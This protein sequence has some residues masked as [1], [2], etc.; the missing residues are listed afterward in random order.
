[1][2]QVLS[3][4]GKPASSVKL[5]P[6]DTPCKQA[7]IDPDGGTGKEGA[8]KDEDQ[9]TIDVVNADS[10]LEVMGKTLSDVRVKTG[11]GLVSRRFGL[12]RRFK[13]K[14]TF[15]AVSVKVENTGDE[16]LDSL[17]AD[18]VLDGKRYS[19]DSRL[20]YYVEPDDAF[21][22]Q[23]SDSV[24]TTVLFDVPSAVVRGADSGG[25]LEI[26]GDDEFSSP[27]YAKKL[28]RIRLGGAPSRGGAKG[29]TS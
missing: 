17:R 15:V 12:V 10:D 18:L 25:A 4:L 5:A 29:V 13:A 6:E 14:G 11:K 24:R 20:G 3:S 16:P 7:G 27:E 28:G 2:V 22:L 23:P 19:E 1:M 8:C 26:S 21:P 9:K